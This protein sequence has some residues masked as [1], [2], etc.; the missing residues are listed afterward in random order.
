MAKSAGQR[1]GRGVWEY[2][3]RD[4]VDTSKDRH[5]E[6]V[7]VKQRLIARYEVRAEFVH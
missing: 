3:H 4:V 6:G 1:L 2:S 7:Y 5:R